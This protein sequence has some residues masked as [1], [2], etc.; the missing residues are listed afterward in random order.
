MEELQVHHLQVKYLEVPEP[1]QLAQLV[2]QVSVSN[3]LPLLELLE[4]EE[5]AVQAELPVPV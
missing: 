4:T 5:L 3:H 2:L 1:G